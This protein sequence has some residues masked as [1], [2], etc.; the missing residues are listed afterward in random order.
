MKKLSLLAVFIALSLI[1]NVYAQAATRAYPLTIIIPRGPATVELQNAHW[2][3]AATE[4]LVIHSN[5]PLHIDWPQNS[6]TGRMLL[7]RNP[8]G[9]RIDMVIEIAA[10]QK[11]VT[12]AFSGLAFNVNPQVIFH[13]NTRTATRSE[14]YTVSI[15]LP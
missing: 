13:G 4:G 1:N 7:T 11:E 14:H 10:R 8:S 9:V 5:G 3:K 15:A 6:P 12:I 2:R